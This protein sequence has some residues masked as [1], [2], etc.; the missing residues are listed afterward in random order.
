MK[1][2]L[3]LRQA[4]LVIAMV[5]LLAA[6]TTAGCGNKETGGQEAVE[7]Q[8]EIASFTIAD[9][10]GDWGFP[11]P[12]SHYA[13]G[14]GYVRMSFIFDTL[15]WKDDRGYIPA[16]AHS[17]EYN[18][19]ENSY[20]FQLNE[21]VTW[22]D[23]G[24]F[25]AADVAFTFDYTREH[26][27]QWVDTGIVKSV[28]TAG[29]YEVKMY[30]EKPY[31]PFLEYVGCTLPILPAH[32]YR[33]VD[34]PE[35]FQTRE[36]CIGTGPYKLA[37]YNK[38]QGTYLFQR[39]D[40]YYQGRPIVERIQ[41]VKT[42]N[43][44][45]AAALRQKQVNAA[46][47]PPEL[48]EEL[49]RESF[50]VL[51]GAHDWVAKLV[52]NHQ[53]EPL[54]G[55]D[56]RQALAYAVDRQTLVDTCLRGHGLAGSPG[57]V[58]SDSLWYNSSLDDY[59]PYDPARAEQI[60][61]GLGYVKNDSYFEKNDKPLEL[62]LLFSAAS[63]GNVGEREAE[64]IK[65]QLENAG[66]KVNLR[67]VDAKTLDSQV[68][69]WQFGLALSGHGGLGGD[70]DQFNR[71]IAGQSFNSA[72]YRDNQELLDALKQQE[73]EMDPGKRKE[74]L[75]KVQELYADD[76]PALPLFYNTYYWVHDGQVNL[77][78]T[79]QGIGIGVPIPLNKMSF[80][81]G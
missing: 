74:H 2:L 37:D 78:Y 73:S 54:S 7:N 34:T 33:D 31:A 43:E 26:P 47:V 59:Y 9:T 53:K 71:A 44:T 63:G 16:L 80:V 69:E 68:V 46:Q 28:E 14:P 21:N 41:F 49:A 67:G 50:T 65:S 1:N 11:A 27:Y 72:R 17:W 45:I 51:K 25:T 75:D 39:Y 30:L 55:K 38:A 10:T 79:R 15:V 77:F 8:N 48:N 60:L 19:E 61:T 52:I 36:A 6:F 57:L 66:I 4:G 22:H 20:T 76:M 13:R 56:F 5:L 24:K 70:P 58:P 12:Y 62:E 3:P 35:Q 40:N 81:S 64:M 29:D 32:I 23:G 42:G 18:R